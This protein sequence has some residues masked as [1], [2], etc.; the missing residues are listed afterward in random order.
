[1]ILSLKDFS[2][3]CFQQK[4]RMLMTSNQSLFKYFPQIWRN[5]S[6][7]RFSSI[8]NGKKMKGGQTHR[9]REVFL[10]LCNFCMWPPNGCNRPWY[11][12]GIWMC[13]SCINCYRPWYPPVARNWVPFWWRR[14]KPPPL[15]SSL[16]LVSAPCKEGKG[17]P[18]VQRYFP[19]REFCI[20]LVLLM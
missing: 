6:I 8:W 18:W 4:Q 5:T 1:M 9:G 2:E 14:K 10:D 7:S 17:R 16:F 19:L 11:S 20:S 15:I 3:N 12:P 13:P